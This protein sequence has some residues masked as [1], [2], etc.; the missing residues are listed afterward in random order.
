MGTLEAIVL[1]PSSAWR[2]AT[3]VLFV[4][5]S[6][7]IWSHKSKLGG[8]YVFRVV[9]RTIYYLYHRLVCH[10]RCRDFLSLWRSENGLETDNTAQTCVKEYSFDRTNGLKKGGT[11]IAQ[12][13][14]AVSKM[15][16]PKQLYVEAHTRRSRKKK[17]AKVIYYIYIY[18]YVLYIHYILIAKFLVQTSCF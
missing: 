16:A 6:E 18:T 10:Q 15:C 14:R 7:E 3:E 12:C 4:C 5:I 1:L 9:P 17:E 2:I 13:V 8:Q 11:S